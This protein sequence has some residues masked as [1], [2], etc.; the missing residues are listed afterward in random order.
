MK[1]QTNFFSIFKIDEF[2]ATPKYIQL[3]NCIIHGI[4]ENL[5]KDGDFL[6]SINQ[7]SYEMDISS[8]TAVKAYNY[9]K[10]KN[11]VYSFVGKGFYI[12][13][14]PVTETYKIFLMF[15]KLS[16]HKKIIY[17]A[18]AEAIGEKATIDFYIYNNNFTLFKK[19]LN[20][21]AEGYTHYVI[22]PHFLENS[23][24]TLE[25]IQ[26]IPENKL[27]LLDKRIPGFE[28]KY[29][30]VYED[31]EHDIYNSLQTAAEELGKYN[32][33]KIIFP[34]YTYHPKE[35][36]NGFFSFCQDYVFQYE[37]VND[38]RAEEIREGTVYISLMEDDLVILVEKI[39]NGNMKIGTDVGVI[40]YNETPLKRIILKGITTMSTNFQQMGKIAAEMVLS[41]SIEHIKIPF[42]LILRKSL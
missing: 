30:S 23:R 20:E 41:G 16:M 12:K 40:S 15:N 2:S 4:K 25:L 8:D 9:L 11:I 27:I 35:I 42:E 33:L 32:T 19:L 38:I 39:L 3:A 37:V 26:T 10:K 31:F 24:Q 28:G 17:D 36:L 29:G 18:F 7:L 5:V 21:H 6:P 34:E 1:E 13:I 14:P 22:I